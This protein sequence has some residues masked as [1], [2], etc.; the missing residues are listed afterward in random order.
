MDVQ[1]VLLWKNKRGKN[2]F[3]VISSVT[4]TKSKLVCSVT[5][6]KS[7]LSSVQI[8]EFGSYILEAKHPHFSKVVYAL[9]M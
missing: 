1:N 8:Y 5:H 2:S 9:V 6:T 3:Q 7:K 4:H